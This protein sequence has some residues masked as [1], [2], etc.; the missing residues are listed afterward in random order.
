MWNIVFRAIFP[1][2][3]CGSTQ[4]LSE[5]RLVLFPVCFTYRK[6]QDNRYAVIVLCNGKSIA[7]KKANHAVGFFL[8]LFD[9][10]AYCLKSIFFFRL[11]YFL[12]FF[13]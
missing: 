13:F 2:F 7:T 10:N 1:M 9:D 5:Y 6:P 8:D 4:N 11:G 12:N 3:L